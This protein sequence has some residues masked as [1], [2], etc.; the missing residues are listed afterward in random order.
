MEGA[1]SEVPVDLRPPHP[2][3]QVTV[4][5]KVDDGVAAVSDLLVGEGGLVEEL[6]R[7]IGMGRGERGLEVGQGALELTGL[8]VVLGEGEGQVVHGDSGAE[9][10]R[11]LDGGGYPEEIAPN[12]GVAGDP[13]QIADRLIRV[14]GIPRQ[15]L[16]VVLRD[17]VHPPHLGEGVRDPGMDLRGRGA[18]EEGELVLGERLLELTSREGL[19]PPKI[20]FPS[21]GGGPHATRNPVA[22]RA[23]RVPRLFTFIPHPVAVRSPTRA[24]GKVGFTRGTASF[25]SS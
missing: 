18:P 6:S 21:R 15:R 3:E 14:G 8:L 12:R 2:R 22:T 7:R 24:L 1:E 19:V 13:D 16:A 5:G 20:A 10:G 9:P 25:S 11:L 23:R 17:L 4:P